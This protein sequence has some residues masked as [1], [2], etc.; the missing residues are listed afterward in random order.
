MWEFY[1]AAS[2]MSFRQEGLN[3]FQVQM[4]SHQDVLPITRDYMIDAENLLRNSDQK[5]RAPK[6][7]SS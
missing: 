5:S 6:S 4:A 7:I 3:V 2:E 1:L